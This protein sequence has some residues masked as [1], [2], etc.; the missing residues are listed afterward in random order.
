M[1]SKL[2]YQLER[3]SSCPVCGFPASNTPD[4]A[5]YD[6]METNCKERITWTAS[7]CKSCRSYF[8]NP[9]PT[10]DTLALA[11]RTYYT[12]EFTTVNSAYLRPSLKKIFTQYIRDSYVNCRLS[13]RPN[14]V[15]IFFGAM[16]FL[17][18]GKRSLVDIAIR[19]GP[20]F[21]C[22]RGRCRVLDVGSGDGRYLFMLET[23]GW[24]CFSIEP[25]TNAAVYYKSSSLKCFPQISNLG[26]DLDGTFDLITFSHSLEHLHD[27]VYAIQRSY[28]LLT[29]SGKIWI[30][31]PNP[32]SSL[33]GLFGSFWRGFEA[34]RHLVLLEK[35][36][37]ARVLT[38]VGFRNIR[39]ISRPD[40]F[41][42]MER[43]SR[44]IMKCFNLDKGQEKKLVSGYKNDYRESGQL[45]KTTEYLTLTADK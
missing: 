5:L 23:L 4:M 35:S 27:P 15:D 14:L 42:F 38:D 36:H 29:D 6:F 7:I 13:I 24:D 39:F 30:D 17:S 3:L 9:R 20:G 37:L 2:N 10:L 45:D 19:Q 31:C 41:E 16:A 25:D 12:H 8:V 18:P 11:Y 21:L 26:A 40:A 1:A 22:R 44:E 34:P 28:R 43:R 33:A 32:Y